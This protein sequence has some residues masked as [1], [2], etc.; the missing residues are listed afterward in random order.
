[1]EGMNH[2]G[3]HMVRVLILV[4]ERRHC[5]QL[6]FVWSGFSEVYLYGLVFEFFLKMNSILSNYHLLFVRKWNGKP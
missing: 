3:S 1:M 5:G 2:R 4:G 6:E